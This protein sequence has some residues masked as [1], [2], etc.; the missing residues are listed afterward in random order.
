M[1]CE[2]LSPGAAQI[3]ELLKPFFPPDP[4]KNPRWNEDGT[5]EDNG[6][7]DLRKSADRHKLLEKTRST[8]GQ[9][10]ETVAGV[11][12]TKNG[13]LEGFENHHF[14]PMIRHK[15][16]LLFLLRDLDFQIETGDFV[17]A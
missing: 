3:F 7:Y 8:L 9:F 11:Y 2:T 17:D 4:W 14:G 1:D 10:V 15:V 12:Q 6:K 5:V 16:G 13:S